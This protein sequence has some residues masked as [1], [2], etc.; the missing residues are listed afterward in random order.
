MFA[1]TV[2]LI[3]KSTEQKFGFICTFFYLYAI[4]EIQV[5]G[6]YY[7]CYFVF[8]SAVSFQKYEFVNFN[9]IIAVLTDISQLCKVILHESKS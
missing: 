4:I 6:K 5:T 2:L 8:Y 1:D 7:L 9:C 3:E